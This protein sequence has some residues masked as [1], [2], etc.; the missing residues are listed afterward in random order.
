MRVG[1]HGTQ[2][3]DRDH[4]DILAAGFMNGAHDVA[5]D[6]A[7]SVDGYPDSHDLPPA[8]WRRRKGG[9]MMNCGPRHF[10]FPLRRQK[11]SKVIVVAQFR[12]ENRFPKLLRN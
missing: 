2:I 12:T 5:A 7:K 9:A 8:C 3:I 4:V 6:A 1:F 11:S 10:C